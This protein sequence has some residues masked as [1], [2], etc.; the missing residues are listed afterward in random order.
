MAMECGLAASICANTS[1]A[2]TT[3]AGLLPTLLLIGTR[4]GGTTALS[5]ILVQHPQVVPPAC[6]SPLLAWPASA[7]VQRKARGT[8]CVWDKETRYFSRGVRV[9]LD[10]CW[11]R[12]LYH[13]AGGGDGGGRAA[14]DGSPDYLVLEKPAVEA[15]ALALGPRA[16]L[17]ALLRNPSDRFYSAYNMAYNERLG[18]LR[19]ARNRTSAS[20]VTYAGFAAKLDR[21]V[22]CAPGCPLEDRVVGMFFNYG[23]YASHL[24]TYRAAFGAGAILVERSEDFYADAWPTVGRV[25]AHFGLP[26]L[27]ASVVAAQRA[28]PADARKRNSGGVWGGAEY[29]GRLLP[30]ERIKLNAFYRPHN[31]E[32]YAM[33]GRDMGWE[34][35]AEARV[36]APEAAASEP[37][38][39]ELR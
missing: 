22:A 10:L 26:A 38:R 34:A 16:R 8:M 5:N 25:V 17:V 3:S 12:S 1:V 37:R 4:K 14:F 2:G 28:K 6:S 11:Y 33:L 30:A 9:G 18:R 24:R 7:S 21:L 32:L 13:C 27:P 15:M 31:A 20:S 29:T 35:E 23:L 39:L 36:T 19:R